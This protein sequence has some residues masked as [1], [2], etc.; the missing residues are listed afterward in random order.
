MTTIAVFS[1][2]ATAPWIV[3]VPVSVGAGVYIGKL[4]GNDERKKRRKH[5]DDDDTGG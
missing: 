3:L 4:F 2:C 5:D 1:I